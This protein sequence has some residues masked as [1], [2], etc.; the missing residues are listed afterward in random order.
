MSY[1]RESLIPFST[2]KHVVTGSFYT[3]F[4]IASCSTNGPREGVEESVVYVSH[5]YDGLLY[6][7]LSE[8]TDGRFEPVTPT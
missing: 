2:W 8:F 7:E 4:G 1:N 5:T 6:R 3:V